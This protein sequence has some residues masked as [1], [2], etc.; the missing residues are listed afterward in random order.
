MRKLLFVLLMCLALVWGI[1][2]CQEARADRWL[3]NSSLVPGTY[4]LVYD[5]AEGTA[6]LLG[7]QT[8][9]ELR[10]LEATL[11]FQ[12]VKEAV[13]ITIDREFSTE[14]LLE[15]MNAEP[16]TVGPILF[17][18]DKIGWHQVPLPCQWVLGDMGT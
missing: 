7:L 14:K 1:F 9:S 18:E 12:S 10:G 16:V 11:K 5:D 2:M 17:K 3:Q 13:V 15:F 6:A 8:Y 4:M